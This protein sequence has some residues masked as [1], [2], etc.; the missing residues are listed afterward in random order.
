ML[1]QALLPLFRA[2]G[3]GRIITV[4]SVV[5]RAP[6]TGPFNAVYA[7]T[8][9]GIDA[10]AEALNKEIASHGLMSVI[11]ELGGFATDMMHVDNFA[12]D[13]L[14]PAGSG[15]EDLGL[16]VKELAERFSGGL[17]PAEVAA[18]GIADVVENSDPPLRTILPVEM[19]EQVALSTRFTDADYWALCKATTVRDWVRAM[20]QALERAA[21]TP[22]P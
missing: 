19:I 11:V 8:K 14:G 1:T 4:S 18:I 20:R 22:T 10:W 7:A 2:Q 6:L 16:F 15:Y 3:H 17:A 21:A 5:R 13:A 9:A 12:A